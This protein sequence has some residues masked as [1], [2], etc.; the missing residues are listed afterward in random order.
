MADVGPHASYRNWTSLFGAVL[1]AVSAVLFL[2]FFLL[3]LLGFHTNP[4]LGIVTFLLLPVLFVLGLLLMP[5]GLW[6]ARRRVAR[7]GAVHEW[8]S[9]DLAQPHVRRTVVVVLVLTCVNAAIIAMAAASSVEYVDSR[10]FCTSVCHT[11]MEPESV[12]HQRSVHASIS[13]TS[14]HVGPGAEG[15]VRAKLGGVR[16]L[17]AVTTGS[18]QRPVPSPVHDLPEAAGTCRG[19]HTPTKYFGELVR[20]IPYYSDDE[21]T[22]E[23]ITTLVMRLGGGGFEAGGPAGI[24]WHASPLVRVEYIATGEHRETIPWVQVSDPKGVREYVVEGATAGQLAGE[25]RVMDCTDC[26]NRIGHNIAATPDRAVDGALARGLLPRDLPFIRR[27]AL[28]AVSMEYP[29][30]STAEQQIAARLTSFY[31]QQPNLASDPRVTQAVRAAL[32]AYTGNV[33]LQMNV[34]WGSYPNNLGHT[35]APGCFRC[36]DDQHKS[37]MGSVISQDCESCHRMQ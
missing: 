36:H 7:G 19:C 11:P 3:D 13:C 16:R 5:F 32:E 21:G 23:Q 24:H 9:I 22:T 18:Y 27:E 28:A 4:Y 8:P 2:A 6:R 1:A 20:S 15:F 29:D 12:A 37:K 34:K 25:R 10:Q 31:A 17:F 35:D 26:H 30:R 14:C 33:F